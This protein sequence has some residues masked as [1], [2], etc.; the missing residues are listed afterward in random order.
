MA[1][2]VR[3]RAATRALPA[4]ESTEVVSGIERPRNGVAEE[5][6]VSPHDQPAWSSA[7]PAVP[8]LV[9]TIEFEGRVSFTLGNA[10][11]DEYG[12]ESVPAWVNSDPDLYDFCE[13]ARRLRDRMGTA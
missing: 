9:I 8:K 10:H 3:E 4:D 2:L 13:L 11:G 12:E 6:C 5:R 1:S 7:T